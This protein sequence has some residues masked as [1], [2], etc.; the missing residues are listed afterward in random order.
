[1][2]KVMKYQDTTNPGKLKNTLDVDDNTAGHLVKEIEYIH[3]G[4]VVPE[5]TYYVTALTLEKG[6]DN[7]AND[8][9][10]TMA[11]GKN[12]GSLLTAAVEKMDRTLVTANTEQQQVDVYKINLRNNHKLKGEVLY[13]DKGL[14]VGAGYQAGKWESMAYAGHGK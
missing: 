8:I 1:M 2:P 3:D 11:T 10:I 14:S 9:K 7:T 13:H 4:K 6:A 12:T 5:T